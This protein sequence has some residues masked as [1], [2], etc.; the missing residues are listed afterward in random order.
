[1]LLHVN[2]EIRKKTKA[3][4]INQSTSIEASLHSPAMNS[5]GICLFPEV[6]TRYSVNSSTFI[7]TQLHISLARLARTCFL[8]GEAAAER[9][10]GVFGVLTAVFVEVLCD[11]LALVLG[12][13]SVEVCCC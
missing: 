4:N 10:P 5:F 13:F 7:I 8:M 1:M 2:S 6:V 9:E 12:V 3:V 11:P